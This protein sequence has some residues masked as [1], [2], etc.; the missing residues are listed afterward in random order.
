MQFVLVPTIKAILEER[1]EAGDLQTCVSLCE[2]LQVVTPEETVKIAELELER[3][4]EWYLAYIDIL[5]EM[6]LFS[7]ATALIK[8]CSDPFISALNKQ[9]T[10][11]VH[12]VWVL[13]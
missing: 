10:T 3:V 13:F 7:E 4:R 1:S 2:V 11:Y 6:C 5:R 12:G 8:N 9:S